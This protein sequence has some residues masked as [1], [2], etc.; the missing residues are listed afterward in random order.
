LDY[1]RVE[2]PGA[3]A[4]APATPL[5]AQLGAALTLTGIDLP[6]TATPGK[7]ILVALYWQA[8]DIPSRDYTRFVHLV[9]LDGRL[10]TQVDGQPLDG[11]YPTSFWH[12]GETV[13][14][15]ATLNVPPDLPPGEYKVRAGLYTQQ[16]GRLPVTRNGAPAGDAVDLGI[17]AVK[18]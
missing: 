6:A 10:V 13:R 1:V 5:D 17:I 8:T 16:G 9:G 18:P 3:Q 14:D 15:I 12:R 7:P 4:R 2:P 11:L